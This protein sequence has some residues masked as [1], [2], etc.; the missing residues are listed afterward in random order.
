MTTF[1]GPPQLGRG[2][3]VRPGQEIDGFAA[4]PR[5]RVDA[6][7]LEAPNE[8]VARL[9]DAWTGR[10]PIVIEFAI[11]PAALQQPERCDAP[12]WSLDVSFSFAREW[13][14][15]LVW[16]NTYDARNTPPKW[17]WAT[18]AA[19]LG[20]SETPGGP[21]DIVLA[22]GTPAWI[23]GGPRGPL[24]ELS[25]DASVVH[26]ES[27]ELGLLTRAT[28]RP[29]SAELAPDQLAAVSHAAGAARVI[30]PAGSGKTRVLTERARHLLEDRG[31][32]AGLVTAVAYNTKA[33]EELRGRLG[34]SASGAQVRTFHALGYALLREFCG[35][36]RLIDEREARER[37]GLLVDVQRAMNTDPIAPYL[38][39][40]AQVRL[41]LRAP[42]EVEA[43]RDD[44]PG[45][46][47][48]FDAYRDALK[49]D[50]AID[51][52]EQIY[53]AI[54]CLL[55][56]PAT[57][58]VAQQRCRHLLVDEFQDL[59]PAF[60]LLTRLLSAP[61]YQVFG[62]GDD[63][64]TIYGY[65]GADPGYLVDFAQL[66]P[67]AHAH[68]LEVNYRCPQ[69]IVAA[70]TDLLRHNARR[71]TKSVRSASTA[72]PDGIT[73]QRVNPERVAPTTV[74]LV[75]GWLQS[76]TAP[77]QIAVL[78]RVNAW[79]LAPQ[80]LLS[81]AGVPIDGGL[82]ARV[83][84]RTGLRSALAYLRGA[85][86]DGQYRG[87]DLAD[88]ANRPS[89]RI[90][91]RARDVLRGRR[92]WSRAALENY[93]AGRDTGRDGERVA[94][95]A[96]DL[97]MLETVATA[98]GATTASVLVHVRDRIGLGTAMQTLDGSS[99]DVNGSHVDDL[100]ALIQVAAVHDDPITFEPW[101][102]SALER[103][104]DADG[105]R[106]ASVHRVK[107][108]EFDHVV[109]LGIHR[110][111]DLALDVEEERRIA[112]VAITRARSS[113][114]AVASRADD[115][116]FLDEMEGR[117]PAVPIRAARV[118]PAPSPVAV[119]RDKK[120]QEDRTV[121]A[122]VGLTITSDD[123][124][125]GEITNIQDA[126]A[127]V[128]FSSRGST[129]LRWG[130][131]VQTDASRATLEPPGFDAVVT[132]LTA[133]RGRRAVHDKVPS[134]VV[135]HNSTRDAIARAQPSTVVALSRC[136][137]IGPTKIERYG[138]DILVVVERALAG[139]R[140]DGE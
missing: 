45:F 33:A 119:P 122:L 139:N 73:L 42:I 102:R 90:T 137:G 36:P 110:P 26:R 126:Y 41:A 125:E 115:T 128:S 58:R 11:D 138:D 92:S 140:S 121:E 84:Q 54:E 117:E 105:V 66:F 29:A 56:D 112:H 37:I 64:Q 44:I 68:A 127:E 46:A 57:R 51:F 134:Y 88:I 113:V 19:R 2:V 62:V 65:A 74:E 5:V 111:H 79:L 49:A 76:G 16:A 25:A 116:P 10:H 38:E 8:V 81:E 75:E 80:V 4:V 20:G 39:A 108:L 82:D 109:A 69:G 120:E 9:H 35:S 101:L 34:A 107:G 78:S 70:A 129:R 130:A 31:V 136:P 30:A 50:N 100:A 93:G 94:D 22:D 106:L 52:D 27:V 3:V 123:G 7:I 13:L 18:K 83:L 1:P 59:T 6:D 72:P 103:D 71:V 43:E 47:T 96:R 104:R 133:W 12:P 118:A 132:A 95:L 86:A 114:H 77:K 21:A 98:P 99:T 67:G 48:A 135:M 17:W 55:R 91:S 89:R 87:S 85:F 28:S 60:V 53:G 14:A 32:E 63:D 124:D 23:D 15:F 131:T 61:A 97:A 40:L 24:T